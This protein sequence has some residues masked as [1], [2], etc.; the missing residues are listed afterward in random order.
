MASNHHVSGGSNRDD[1]E[2]PTWAMQPQIYPPG[3]VPSDQALMESLC[4]QLIR[5]RWTLRY[6]PVHDQPDEYGLPPSLTG[7][8]IWIQKKE[9]FFRANPGVFP[10]DVYVARELSFFTWIS[11][12]FTPYSAGRYGPVQ[13]LCVMID[14][15][16]LWVDRMA[17]PPPVFDIPSD[18]DSGCYDYLD[19]RE[20]GSS[21]YLSGTDGF[22]D[23]SQHI[24]RWQDAI[25]R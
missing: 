14:D 21:S 6:K 9:P 7:T 1:S 3:V 8:S 2:E 13:D 15:Y 23:S 16:I 12:R 10:P 5:D 20:G 4:W 17:A 22:F 25:P 11:L 18:L 24:E 19:P